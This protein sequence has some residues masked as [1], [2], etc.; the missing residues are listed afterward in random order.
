MSV[1][2][3]KQ[4]GLVSYKFTNGMRID[5]AT[6][7]VNDIH[8]GVFSNSD[9]SVHEI[10]TAP[11]HDKLGAGLRVT[12]THSD[13]QHDI[14][15]VQH[16]TFYSSSPYIIINAEASARD[17]SNLESRDI[18]PLAVL[19]ASGGKL[20]IPGN[21]PR[22]LDAPFDN[23]NWVGVVQR[24][25]AKPGAPKV[26]GISY[27]FISLYDR[28]TFS[29]LVMGS[30]RHDFWKTGIVYRA[31]EQKGSIDSLKIFG[32]ATT[33]DHKDLPAAY[34]G[35]DGTHDLVE[36]GTMKGKTVSSPDIYLAA[37]ADIRKSLTEYGV[38]NAKINGRLSWA[39]AAPVYWNSFGVENVLGASG[40]MMLSGVKQTSDFLHTLKNLSSNSKP[41][42]SID[43]YD[44]KYILQ[45]F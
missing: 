43:S 31:A 8:A 12:I 1:S 28:F 32:G 35:Y 21:D 44:Q 41:V 22:I 14:S 29:G 42:L 39:G 37:S 11:V 7:Y 25:W 6:A 27:D 5:N 18:C 3:S 4:T 30:I 36:H 38:V 9:Y 15:L 45:K 24:S 13:N 34:G 10:S 17:K 23:D 16:L 33:P 2:V 40:I 26:S 19:P 20:T